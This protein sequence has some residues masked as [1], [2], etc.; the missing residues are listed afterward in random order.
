[1]KHVV[2]AVADFARPRA[3]SAVP[4][5]SEARVSAGSHA[6]PIGPGSQTKQSRRS[7][8]VSSSHLDWRGT[9]A[10][11]PISPVSTRAGYSRTARLMRSIAPEN[12]SPHGVHSGLRIA[13]PWSIWLAA[14]AAGMLQLAAKACVRRLPR[15]LEKGEPGRPKRGLALPPVRGTGLD[16]MMPLISWR[17]TAI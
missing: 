4:V 17:L 15:A 10:R 3:K 12:G 14:M 16:A 13:P 11:R 1:M 6:Y 7:L 5:R 8:S 2:R 9:H